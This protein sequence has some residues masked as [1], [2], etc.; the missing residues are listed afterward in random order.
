MTLSGTTALTCSVRVGPELIG[1]STHVLLA[2]VVP[3]VVRGENDLAL[4][5]ANKFFAKIARHGHAINDS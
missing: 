3:V 4:A 5:G 2:V 1:V